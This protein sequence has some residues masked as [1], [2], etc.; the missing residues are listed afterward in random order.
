MSPEKNV[1]CQLAICFQSDTWFFWQALSSGCWWQFFFFFKEVKLWLSMVAGHLEFD[2]EFAILHIKHLSNLYEPWTLLLSDQPL[3]RI[4]K[5][6]MIFGRSFPPAKVL[7]FSGNLTHHVSIQLFSPLWSLKNSKWCSYI[8][9][10][11]GTRKNT[12]AVEERGSALVM[13]GKI[14][15]EE[16]VVK[17]WVTQEGFLEEVGQVSLSPG[18][19]RGSRDQWGLMTRG[20]EQ[21]M[22][23]NFELKSDGLVRK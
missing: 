1:V 3:W 14:V 5:L 23:C 7:L 12:K 9:Q 11:L 19:L 6:R 13:K 15:Q 17:A 10:I 2:S 8:R 22:C 18:K 21:Y 20:L 4:N 16:H